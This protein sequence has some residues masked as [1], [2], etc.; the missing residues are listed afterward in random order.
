VLLSAAV[1]RALSEAD[2]AA[3]VGQ[4]GDNT[5]A[6]SHIDVSRLDLDQGEYNPFPQ[7]GYLWCTR[8]CGVLS[9]LICTHAHNTG[10]GGVTRGS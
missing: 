6:P 4:L 8:P 1:K 3:A 10:G 7:R 2:V 9:H 5:L